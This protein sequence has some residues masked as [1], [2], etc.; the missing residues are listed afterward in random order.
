[1]S[2][3]ARILSAALL[4]TTLLAG[5][6]GSS[7]D[8]EKAGD[9]T[10]TTTEAS[11]SANDLLGPMNKATGTPVKIGVISDGKGPGVDNSIETP[12]AQATAKWINER[13]G[14]FAGHPIELVICENNQDPAKAVDCANQLITAKV[15]AV[16]IPSSGVVESSWTPLH[17]SGIP[18]MMLGASNEKI[19][20]DTT[21]TF[22]LGSAFALSD[23]P[24]ALA[25]EKGVKKVSIVVIDVP[26]ATDLYKGTAQARYKKQGL[27]LE[28]IPVA[29]GTADMTPQMQKLVSNNPDGV[30]SVIGN[31]PF[32]IAAFNG[33]RTAGF[34]GTV[35]AVPQCI[36]EATKTAVPGSF[37]KGV[38]ISATNP[39]QDSDDASVKQYW[40]VLDA[41]GAA[42]ADKTSGNG[43][44]MFSVLASLA[45]AVKDLKGD[46]TPA[47]VTAA[48]KAMKTSVMP[49][50]GGQHFRCDG[51]ASEQPS[52]CSNSLLAGTLDDKGDVASFKVVG[53]ELLN[54]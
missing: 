26:A 44:V 37:L 41:Y 2:S 20:N 36:T 49:G 32:C 46:I 40:A 17:E 1:M 54:G 16:A 53:D 21:S 23:F 19:L 39:L 13:L 35:S 31:D 30:V 28:I 48:I 8:D 22:T 10:T 51:K 38:Q 34:R 50:T 29:P 18:V 43:I 27:Q 11:S 25:K 15:P 14:G 45:E 6:C 12:V 33:M 5:A 4:A 52:A 3:R 7:S 47:S 9:A 24:A 42:S